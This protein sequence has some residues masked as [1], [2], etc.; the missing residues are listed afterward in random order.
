MK[1]LTVNYR[2]TKLAIVQTLNQSGLPIDMEVA[3]LKDLYV[4]AMQQADIIYQ[5]D[6]EEMKKAEKESKDGNSNKKGK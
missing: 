5:R 6:L 3:I 4:E 2:D 1:P